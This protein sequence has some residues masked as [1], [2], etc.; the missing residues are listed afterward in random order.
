LIGAVQGA[1]ARIEPVSLETMRL[2]ALNF[3]TIHRIGHIDG[4]ITL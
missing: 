2:V 4:W 3:E 1:L